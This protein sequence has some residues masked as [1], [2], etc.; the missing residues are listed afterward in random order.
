MSGR[1]TR[2]EEARIVKKG[3][4]RPGSGVQDAVATAVGWGED[5]SSSGGSKGEGGRRTDGEVRGGGGGFGT[6]LPKVSSDVPFA[7]RTADG[8]DAME[9]LGEVWRRRR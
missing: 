9:I 1:L 4:Y 5:G 2:D 7:E 3:T 8:D 6:A